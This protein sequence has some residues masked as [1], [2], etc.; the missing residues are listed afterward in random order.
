MLTIAVL[1]SGGGSN[2]QAIIDAIEAGRLGCKVAVVIS[3]NATAGAL[4]RGKLHN[5]PTEV[6]TK[7]DY[8][9]REDYDKELTRVL[10][11]YNV[12]LIVLAGFM[13][14]LSP[15]MVDTFPLK[16][17]NIHPALLPSFP[18]L[19]VQ[20]AAIEASVRFSGCTVHF[21]DSGVDTGPIIIQAVV[22]VLDND[23]VEALS[24]RILKEEHRIYPEAIRLIA[25]GSIE[26]KNGLVII[27]GAKVNAG[28]SLTNPPVIKK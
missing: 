13:R 8:P 27:T 19:N 17:I 9:G 11:G 14:V 24:E 7:A 21:V 2:L 10:M 28:D 3:D 6:I 20:K 16:I 4:E 25:E 18:G 1:A 12:E 15:V 5:I 22:P 26:F 23:T